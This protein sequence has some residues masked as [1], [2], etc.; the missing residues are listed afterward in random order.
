MTTPVCMPP[1]LPPDGFGLRPKRRQRSLISLTPLIDVV[2]ILLIFFMLASSFLDWRSIALGGGARA[3][4]MPAPSGVLLVEVGPQGLRLSGQPVSLEVLAAR[5]GESLRA[6]HGQRVLV[7]P[8][9]GVT[10][11]SLVVVVDRL[12]EAGAADLTLIHDPDR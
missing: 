7:R 6:N 12:T 10:L 4:G 9:A 11:Q 5:I 2:F 3:G 1:R 8:A